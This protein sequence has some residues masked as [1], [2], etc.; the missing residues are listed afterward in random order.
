MSRSL[1]LALD[2]GTTGIRA[3]LFDRRGTA[4]SA[5]YEELVVSCPQPGW[6][7]TD[8][9]DLWDAARRVITAAMR[10]AGATASD[11]A[12][13]GIANQRATTVLWERASGRPLRPAIVWQDVRT[14]A[15]VAELQSRGVFATTMA[16]ASKLERM[17]SDDPA[18]RE[19]AGRGEI[20]FGTVDTWLLW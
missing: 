3:L 1:L 18:V 9:S 2:A 6:V 5:A 10:A 20:C 14:A 19:R 11:V 4:R 16:S 12:A 8:A 13:I 17:L 7:E 15:R